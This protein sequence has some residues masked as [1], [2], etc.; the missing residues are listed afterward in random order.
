MNRTSS[1]PQN[2][3]LVLSV[4]S[5]E[6]RIVPEQNSV[7]REWRIAVAAADRKVAFPFTLFLDGLC[8]LRPRAALP[9]QY[10]IC[11]CY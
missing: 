1:R 8:T 2:S 9:R 7:A 3:S 4:G 10:R 5:S 6:L 11:R